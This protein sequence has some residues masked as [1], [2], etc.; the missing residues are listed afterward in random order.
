MNRNQFLILLVIVAVVGGAGLMLSKQ[1]DAGW[2]ASSTGADKSWLGD[3]PVNDIAQV[4]IKQTQGEVT[5]VKKDDLW[6]VKERDE[7]PANF[8]TISDFIR[9][10]SQ[11]KA[12]QSEPIG[13]S[14]LGRM[15][16]LPPDKGANSGTLVEFKDQSGKPIKSLI[17]GKPYIKKQETPSPYG[18][19]DFPSGRYILDQA[20]PGTMVLVADSLSQIEPKAADWLDKEF[21]R[22]EKVKSVSLTA[23]NATNS[24]TLTR[25]TESTDWKLTDAKPGEELDKN[26]NAGIAG[27]LASLN[28]VDVATGDAAKLDQPAE[29][30]VETF[31]N[32]SYVFKIAKSGEENFNFKMS[33]NASPAKERKPGTDEKPEDKEKLEKEF[34]DRLKQ[35]EDKLAQEKKFEKWTFVVSKWAVEGLLKD[36]NQ[37]MVEKKDEK[38]EEKPEGK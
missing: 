10:A 23:T 2:K 31:D 29:V 12:I 22:V 25:E 13:A 6:R 38:K 18:G 34:K 27:P 16:L 5:L 33:V 9:K 37:L 7:Y 14:Q 8:G 26:K 11:W 19:G 28:F 24:W 21:F 4:Q 1:R 17:L 35:L 20:N 36:R 30:K 3:L 15:L 32:F